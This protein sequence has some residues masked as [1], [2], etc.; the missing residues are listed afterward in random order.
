MDKMSGG[1]SKFGKIKF[2]NMVMPNFMV[3]FKLLVDTSS[4]SGFF[5]PEAKLVFAKCKQAFIKAPI[6]HY[7]DLEC[8]IHGETN[9]LSYGIG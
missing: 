2:K 3:K 5:T 8:Y 9:V 4:K 6:F 7:F 1:N